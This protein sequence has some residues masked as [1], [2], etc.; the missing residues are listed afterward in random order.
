MESDIASIGGVGAGGTGGRAYLGKDEERGCDFAR[1]L[2]GFERAR[3]A[4]HG[5]EGRMSDGLFSGRRGGSVDLV[6]VPARPA[7]PEP[8]EGR[9]T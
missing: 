4:G 9:G 3:R 5:Q 8:P 6:R 1:R 2:V 7:C